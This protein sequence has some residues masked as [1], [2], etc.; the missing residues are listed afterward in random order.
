MARIMKVKAGGDNFSRY[1]I[2]PVT[3]YRDETE[4]HALGTQGE[5]QND[6]YLALVC[7]QCGD[8]IDSPYLTTGNAGE[9][10]KASQG[11]LN[12]LFNQYQFQ[13]ACR[14]SVPA[15]EC[16]AAFVE[17]KDELRAQGLL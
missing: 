17:A 13:C 6:E 4:T 5:R 14:Q 9:I 10:L 7:E 1:R 16:I 2:N 15:Q 11:D 12:A 8:D 3:N